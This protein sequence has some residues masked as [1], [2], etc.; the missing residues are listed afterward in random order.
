MKRFSILFLI[1]ALVSCGSG[2]SI[3]LNMEKFDQSDV[4]FNIPK[5]WKSGSF[6]FPDP[7]IDLIRGGF[8][9]VFYPDGQKM[10]DV[11]K[12]VAIGDFRYQKGLNL[13]SRSMLVFMRGV[14]KRY[15]PGATQR[16][17]SVFYEDGVSEYKPSIVKSGD[18]EF[19]ACQALLSQPG[20]KFDG[21]ALMWVCFGRSQP[22]QTGLVH[23]F[24]SIAVVAKH[25]G[26]SDRDVFDK[27][28]SSF[29]F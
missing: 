25:I 14:T 21:E 15:F 26:Q 7:A 17:G 22:Y 16:G 23:Q 4:S 3:P 19:E 28:V 1:L 6:T 2:G 11:L 20:V 13:G 5:G 8:Q 9:V 10:D 27:V 24:Y 12:E 18:V 29:K